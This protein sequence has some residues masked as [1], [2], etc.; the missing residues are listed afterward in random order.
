[1]KR[2]LSTLMRAPGRAAALILTFHANVS[3]RIT[4][5]H[6]GYDLSVIISALGSV[7]HS[8]YIESFTLELS[9]SPVLLTTLRQIR[10][11]TVN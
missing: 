9:C 4:Y 6:P 3:I 1:M 2:A 5:P 7:S 11:A 8:L 10:A